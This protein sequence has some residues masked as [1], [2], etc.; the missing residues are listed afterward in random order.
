M[1]ATEITLTKNARKNE[2]P[3]KD[4]WS[5]SGGPYSTSGGAVYDELAYIDVDGFNEIVIETT[6]ALASAGTL[7][8]YASLKSALTPAGILAGDL[9]GQIGESAGV[10]LAASGTDVSRFEGGYRWIIVTFAKTAAG[11]GASQ[12]TLRV[13]GT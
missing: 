1:A 12:I 9:P 7:K 2:S 8:F 11:A 13:H 10:A 4:T 5:G 6:N 3:N